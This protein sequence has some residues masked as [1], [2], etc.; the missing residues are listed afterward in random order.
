MGSPKSKISEEGFALNEHLIKNTPLFA[1]LT[2][3]EQRA[4]GKRMRLETYQPNESIFIKDRESNALYLIEEGWVK[5]VA[6]D[7]GPAVANLGPGSLLGE[8]DFFTGQLYTLTARASGNV[9]VWV[10]DNNALAN[11]MAERPEI[12][13]HLGMALGVGIAQYQKYLA[14]Q[15]AEVPLLENLSE[16]ERGLIAGHLSPQRYFSGEAIYRSADRPVGLFF[17]EK[18]AVRL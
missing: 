8:T 1:E 9:T 15:L 2:D 10:L 14:Q 11:L 16:R 3:D 17:I 12:G 4:L 7:R 18:G 5:L 6:N 13:L